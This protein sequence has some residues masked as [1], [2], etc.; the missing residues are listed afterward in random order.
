MEVWSDRYLFSDQSLDDY[1]AYLIKNLRNN[2]SVDISR[3]FPN[4]INRCSY[5]EGIINKH[6]EL[7]ADFSDNEAHFFELLLYDV[8]IQRHNL[9]IFSPPKV[10]LYGENTV[11]VAHRVRESIDIKDILSK[12]FDNKYGMITN[13]YKDI[14]SVQYSVVGAEI[15]PVSNQKISEIGFGRALCFEDAKL[16][17]VL[18][19]MERYSMFQINNEIQSFLL[20]S[21][22]KNLYLRE[23]FKSS[24]YKKVKCI[25]GIEL[26]SQEDVWLPLQFFNYVNH[27]D[28]KLVSETSNGMALG[29]SRNEARLYALLEFIERDAFLNFWHKKIPLKRIDVKSL[30]ADAKV[31]IESFETETK[32]VYLFDM[33]LDIRIPVVV[34]LV[35]CPE[36]KPCTYITSAAHL[37]YHRAANS[38]LKEAIVAHNIYSKN[39]A[40]GKVYNSPEEVVELSDHYNY[41][42][43]PEKIKTYDF[44]FENSQVYPI[45]ELYEKV[46]VKTDKEALEFILKK[47]NHI[48]SI[49]C[50][51][52]INTTINDCGFVVS[53]VVIPEMQTMYFGNAN[54]RINIKRME[55][56]VDN[57]PYKNKNIIPKG[58]YN[59]EPHPFP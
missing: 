19:A 26:H 58:S 57:S 7:S 18:E 28:F 59:N 6:K 43:R 15:S 38:A 50:C 27:D 40:V 23:E 2:K 56:A 4:E 3:D 29:G 22:F 41:Y 31:V 49:Y 53:K 9:P 37:N 47:M 24:L 51:E 39:P 55:E 5:I 52:L 11:N 20:D 12:I 45:D 48:K 21:I 25:K 44:L 36:I 14:N 10:D 32:K 33:S 8:Q 34:C 35:V 30:D 16:E 17:A 1:E 46:E 54:K 13:F 42:S